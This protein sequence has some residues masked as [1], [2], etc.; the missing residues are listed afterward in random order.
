M[1]SELLELQKQFEAAQHVKSSV[2][3]SERNVVELVNKL[4]QLDLLDSDLLHT[5]SG[6]EYI[7]QDKLRTEM[8]AE[9]GRLGRVS[10]IELADI[11][12]VDLYHIERQ[13]EKIVANDAELMLVQGEILSFRYWDSVA[14]E[15]NE[16]LQ[17]S[18]H[19]SLAELAGQFQVSSE[20]ITSILEPRLGTIVQGK[21]EGGQLYTPSHVARIRAMIRGAV[22][23]TMVPTNLSSVWSSIHHLLQQT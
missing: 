14:E 7:T 2:R 23:G 22:R 19:I 6:K 16:R 1:D 21:L 9:I 15:I 13:A 10:L 3:L 17:E 11:I 18:S 8:E 20:L 4:Q 5:V 12:G